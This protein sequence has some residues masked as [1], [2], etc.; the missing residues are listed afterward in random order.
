M[1][2]ETLGESAAKLT[3][4]RTSGTTPKT[5]V[6]HDNG[7]T[8][9]RSKQKARVAGDS[10]RMDTEEEYPGKREFNSLLVLISHSEAQET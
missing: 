10:L 5:R 6:R 3:D 9:G 4:Q 1:M 8:G 7:R 2:K